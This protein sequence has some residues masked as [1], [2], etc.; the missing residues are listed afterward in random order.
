[1]EW[2]EVARWE[3]CYGGPRGVL[4]IGGD[5]GQKGEEGF[6]NSSQVSMW[7]VLPYAKTGKS[8]LGGGQS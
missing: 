3:R 6:K 5:E 2:G 7:M 8:R 4:V 1:M